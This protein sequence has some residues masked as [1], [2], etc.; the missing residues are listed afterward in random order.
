L[1]VTL[2]QFEVKPGSEELFERVYGSEGDWVQLFRRD[3]SYR[4]T[5]LLRE[6]ARERVYVTIDEWESRERYDQFRK[7]CAA[8]YAEMDRKCEGLTESEKHLAEH[9][10]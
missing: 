9:S 10:D 4:G 7:K 6:V 2:W 8:A 5:R 3:P 1:F